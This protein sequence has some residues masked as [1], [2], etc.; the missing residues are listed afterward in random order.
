MYDYIIV[1]A[2]FFGSVFAHEAH[3]RGKKVLVLE[4]RDHIGGNA[5]TKEVE[6]IHIHYYG[7]HIFHTKHQAIWDY[8]NQFT[9]FNH[10][11]NSPIANYKN[12]VYN[13]PFNMN[14]FS[15]LFNV[16]T[17]EEAMQKIDQERAAYKD[18]EPKNLEEQAL[19]LVGKTIY[20]KLIKGYTEKQWGKKATDLPAFIIRRLPLRFKYDN[21]YFDDPYQGVPVNGYTEIFKKLLEGIEVRLNTDFLKNKNEYLK[22]AKK[23]IYTGTIDSYYDYQFGKLEYRSLTFDHQVLDINNFQGNAVV[24]YTDYETPYT[25]IL[26]HKHFYFKNDGKTVITYEYP[27]TYEIGDEPYYNVNDA[28]NTNLYHQYKAHADTDEKVIFGG[29]LGLYRYYNMDEVIKEALSLVEKELN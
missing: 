10:Y 27:K 23:I 1:G 26:E 13:L 28:K 8:M 15:K 2:G 3:K 6:G 4:K 5:Y 12:E 29:R 9:R 17:P 7:A 19:K 21:N 24:N 25:R 20:E 22:Q 11:I 18:I 16:F 14:T